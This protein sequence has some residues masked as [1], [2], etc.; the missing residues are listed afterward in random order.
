M[1][2]KHTHPMVF[3]KREAGCP[4]CAELA[5]GAAPITWARRDD[6]RQRSH[7]VR[8]HDCERSRCGN[9]CTFGDY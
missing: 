7:E 5:S 4:R 8:A 3:G 9:V 2:T 6:D 1:T